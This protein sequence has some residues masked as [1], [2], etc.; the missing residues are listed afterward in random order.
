MIDAYFRIWPVSIMSKITESKL[1]IK[2]PPASEVIVAI[3]CPLNSVLF[4]LATAQ[5]MAAAIKSKSTTRLEA[6][7]VDPN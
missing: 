4:K 5:V 3:G 2:A 6:K 1:A 7:T